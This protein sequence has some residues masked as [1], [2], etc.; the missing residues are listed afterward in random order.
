M[1]KEPAGHRQRLSRL[2]PS[3]RIPMSL[4]SSTIGEIPPDWDCGF[5]LPAYARATTKCIHAFKHNEEYLIHQGTII[6]HSKQDPTRTTWQLEVTQYV[7]DLLELAMLQKNRES[8][9][10]SFRF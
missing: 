7:Y 5:D 3:A 8:S 1:I 6:T 10:R 4:Q 2:A 9:T